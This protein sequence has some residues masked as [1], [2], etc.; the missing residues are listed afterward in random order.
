MEVVHPRCA[1]LDVHSETVVACVRIQQGARARHERRTFSTTTKGLKG[2]RSWLVAEGVT[3]AVMESTGVYWKPVWH[4]LSV[5]IQLLLANAMQVKNLPGRKSDVS[6]ATWL[7]DLL[8]HGLIRASMVPPT[9]FQELRDLTRTRSQ[10]LAERSRYIR[11]IQKALEDANVKLTNVMANVMGVTGRALLEALVTGQRI[12]ESFV[13]ATRRGKLKSTPEQMM[14]AL[15]GDVRPH[16]RFL[17]ELH[18][19]QYDAATRHVAAIESRIE[20]LMEPYRVQLD[21]L[22][23]IP[24][25]KAATAHAVLAEIGPDMS[26]FPSSAHLVS[27]AGLCPGQNESAGKR[28]SSG[29]RRGP[30]WL[31]TALVQAAWAAARK[32][33]SYF[34]AQF[35]R[36]RARRGP[37]KAIVAVAASILTS[38]FH[39]LSRGL[40]YPDLGAHHYDRLD[41][42]RT[43]KRLVRRLKDL[44]LDV[45]IRP[46][47]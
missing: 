23:T 15:Q 32:K 2:L 38:V 36:L 1:G 12:D 24:G 9:E 34:R 35:H 14:E 46:A 27:W 29:V 18:I 44:G 7:S 17:L 41:P 42:D 47:A 39:M 4:V 3:H 16:H 13:N 28:R 37:R 40:P 33:D 30:R 22:K 43:A 26:R 20:K 45:Q 31:K 5:S 21:L 19:R 6:D 8:A 10:L 11:R 25:V